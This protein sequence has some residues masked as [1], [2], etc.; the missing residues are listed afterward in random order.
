MT[1][2]WEVFRFLLVAPIRRP[3][4][5]AEPMAVPKILA[6]AGSLRAESYN[7]KL[8]RL[9]ADAARAAGAEVTVLDLRD[10]PLPL[11]DED[12]E[13]SAGLPENARELKALMLAHQGLLLSCP[14]YNS[15]ITAVLKNAIDWASR[16]VPGEASLA[17]FTG[18]VAAL[19]SASPGALGGLRGLV[20]VRAILGNIGVLVLP[21][22]LAVVKSHEVFDAAGRLKDPKQ[23]ETVTRIAGRLVAVLAK[24]N[25]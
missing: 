5:G 16:P 19:L 7:K 17:C 12:L 9:A 22:Q 3:P 11:F 13:K 25:G 24:L 20:H 8:V 15:S 6:F 10:L 1:S 18:K 4:Q 23:Q 21:E 2:A 14:E